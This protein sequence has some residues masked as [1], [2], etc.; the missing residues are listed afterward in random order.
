MRE[1]RY[2]DVEKIV[3]L[4]ALA[5]TAMYAK[6]SDKAELKSHSKVAQVLEDCKIQKGNVYDKAVV[7]LKGL[8]QKHPFASANRRTAILVTKLFLTQNKY[9][10]NV[11][12]EKIQAQ[13][14]QGIRENF[15]SDE[16]IKEWIKN[17]QIQDFKR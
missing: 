9:T 1:L 12:D 2:P 10:F 4:N 13:N 3:E 15:Y 7:L 6:K 11:K 8:I 17:G 5:I 16:E 14:L